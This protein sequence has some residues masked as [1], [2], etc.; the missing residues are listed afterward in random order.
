MKALY[1]MAAAACLPLAAQAGPVTP[2]DVEFALEDYGAEITGS[3][4][5]GENAHVIYAEL[6][7]MPVYVR[8]GECDQF[9]ECGIV[10]MFA[11]F[12]IEDEIDEATLKKTNRYNDSYPIGR[13]FIFP[14][15]DGARNVVGI[16]YVIDVSGESVIDGGDIQRFDRAVQSYVRYWTQEQAQ[17]RPRSEVRSG[18]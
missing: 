7:D 1:A 12:D 16:D 3:E 11:A 10:V 4:A 17:A 18:G 8:L 9:D 14:S 6:S 2:N 13:A 5:I 15:E